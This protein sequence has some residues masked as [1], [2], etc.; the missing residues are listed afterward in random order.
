MPFAT[1]AKRK[2]T[3]SDGAGIL[4]YAGIGGVAPPLKAFE[5]V[6]AVVTDL[7]S[8]GIRARDAIVFALPSLWIIIRLRFHFDHSVLYLM[9][10]GYFIQVLLT[11]LLVERVLVRA[12][13]SF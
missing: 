12:T 13:T 11:L 9:L 1:N 2:L 4:A 5:D 8:R 10:T 7:L 3:G 6:R